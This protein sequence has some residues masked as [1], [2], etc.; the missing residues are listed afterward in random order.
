MVSLS[1]PKKNHRGL[2]GRLVLKA[3]SDLHKPA[4]GL[5]FHKVRE[6]LLKDYHQLSEYNK[7]HNNN[8]EALL[9]EVLESDREERLNRQ[10]SSGFRTVKHA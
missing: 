4:N 8:S 7:Q 5:K 10:P 2:D 9:L 1:Q 3:L 6:E